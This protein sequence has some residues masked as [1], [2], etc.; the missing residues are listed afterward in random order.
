MDTQALKMSVGDEAASSS[1][2]YQLLSRLWLRE[3]DSELVQFLRSSPIRPLFVQAG[4]VVPE[5]DENV[6]DELAIDYCQLFLG[7]A[8]HLP[9]Y[10]SV[11]QTGQFQS[12]T[13]AAMQEFIDLV[14]FELEA[15]AE[16]VMPDH[17]GLQLEIM[18]GI[19]NRIATA[20]HGTDREVMMEVARI[21]F[22]R[23]LTWSHQLLRA[24]VDRAGSDF[25]RSVA[26]LTDEF[27]RSERTALARSNSE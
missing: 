16:N 25:Y 17:L 12:Q 10:Q 23:H 27:L 9:P 5:D 13:S 3:A 11:W 15:Q 2:V 8:D 24:V 6:I 20:G 26:R 1:G 14:P 18:S 7:P 21:F 19:L 4:G 22:D